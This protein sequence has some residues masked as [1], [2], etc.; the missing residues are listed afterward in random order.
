MIPLVH[1][2]D[3]AESNDFRF[4]PRMGDP[5]LRL[6]LPMRQKLKSRDSGTWEKNRQVIALCMRD[7]VVS[8]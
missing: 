7:V 8:L 2:F 5:E 6:S 3:V 4:R 1:N